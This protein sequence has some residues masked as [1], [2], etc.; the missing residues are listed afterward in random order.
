MKAMINQVD[1]SNAAR[2]MSQTDTLHNRINNI[3]KYVLP[4]DTSHLL[5][6]LKQELRCVPHLYSCVCWRQASDLCSSAIIITREHY[7]DPSRRSAVT[8][9]VSVGKTMCLPNEDKF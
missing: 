7:T 2:A 9:Y 6:H 1:S 5:N 4:H 3:S 8:S